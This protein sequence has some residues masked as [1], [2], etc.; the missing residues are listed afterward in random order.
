MSLSQFP[1]RVSL[2]DIKP[3][4]PTD[5]AHDSQAALAVPDLRSPFIRAPKKPTTDKLI[6]PVMGF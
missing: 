6:S 2:T 1:Q 3:G 5:N 4:T